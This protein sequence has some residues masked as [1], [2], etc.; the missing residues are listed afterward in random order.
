M[1]EIRPTIPPSAPSSSVASQSE[2]LLRKL[3]DEFR[4]SKGWMKFLGVLSIIQGI[5]AIF[6]IWGIL[7]CWLPIWIG[8]ILFKAADDAEMASRGAPTRLLDYSMRINRY[9]TIQGILALV[10]IVAVL[11]VL[12]VVGI[13]ALMFLKGF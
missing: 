5:M 6:T 11:I 10:A 4:R 1:E 12:M 13:G 8:L 2:E 3:T 9:F 7:I